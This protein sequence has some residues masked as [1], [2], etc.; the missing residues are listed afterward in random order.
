MVGI[1]VD[2]SV[3]AYAAGNKEVVT[4]TF[5]TALGGQ[6]NAAVTFG[7]APTP[8]AIRDAAGN[9][10][11]SGYTNGFAV[12][13]QGREGDLADRFTGGGSGPLASN[14]LQVLNNFFA[15]A[16]MNPAFN[17]FQR[18]DCAPF[19]SKGNGRL[20]SSDY[21]QLLNFVA[22]LNPPQSAG[23]QFE[24]ASAI[25]PKFERRDPRKARTMSISSVPAF[26]GEQA[27][28]SIDMDTFGDETGS[29]FTLEFDVARLGNPVVTLGSGMPVE[30][31]LVANMTRADRG[32]LGILLSSPQAL[33]RSASRQVVTITFDVLPE[34]K[35]GDT[36]LRLVDAF[37]SRSVSNA[38]ADA[39]PTVY[40]EGYLKIDG[41]GL[42]SGFL[43]LSRLTT[44]YGWPSF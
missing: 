38:A 33:G 21:Q 13:Q 44:G 43:N 31:T 40:R 20:D 16:P 25:P 32:E 19:G 15:G 1:M 35:T 28:V 17:E 5:H 30:T 23:G 22:G 18:A 2:P 3:P 42:R 24:Q 4:A 27:I 6:P 10:H 7:D 8:R 11:L 36:G 9:L 26:A 14:D 34:A 39:L 29:S 12:F 37:I 41:G